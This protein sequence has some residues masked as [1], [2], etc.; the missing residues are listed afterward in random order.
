MASNPIVTTILEHSRISS[1]PGTIGE[2]SLPLTFF[3]ITWLAFPPVHHVFFYRFPHSK[4]HFL[5][6][7]VPNLKHSLSLTLQHFFPFASNLFVYPNVDDF[8]VIRKPEIRHVEGDY[9]ALTIAE[10]CLNFNYLTGNHPRECENFHPLVPPL[11]DLIKM[12]DYVTIPLFSV[13]VTYFKD[14][15]ISIGMTNHHTVADASTRLCFLKA[16]TSIAKSGGDQSFV[17][18]G[19]PPVLDRLID[20]PKLDEYRLRHTSLETLYQPR[21]LVGPTKKVRATFILSRT[22]INQLKKRVLTQIPTLEYI[23]SFTVTCGYIWSCIAKSLVKMGEKKG[24]D[25]LEQFIISVDCRSRMNPPIPSTYLGNC[26]APCI[27][28]IKNVVLTSENGFVFAAKLISEDINKMVKN[29]E[30][31]LKDAERWHEGFKIPARKISVAGTPKLNFYDIDFGWGKPQKYETISIDYSVGGSVAI[32]ASKESTQD[33]E[34]GLSFPNMQ[35][36]AFADIFNHG[37]ESE[38]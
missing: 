38:I 28:T 31:I 21:S 10:C 12:S 17:M 13:Q 14:S 25:E 4:S 35:M 22:N 3:D 36:K 26:G 16:W 33:F 29:K 1:P 30:G 27:T 6:T 5:E 23:S 34:I 11:G 32:N 7:V 9:V 18:N 15:G 24:E 20:I 2:R 8:G 37:L 19:S